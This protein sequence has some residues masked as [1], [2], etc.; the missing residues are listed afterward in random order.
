MTLAVSASCSLVSWWPLS[1]ESSASFPAPESATV[2]RDK[3]A[4]VHCSAPFRTLKPESCS[5][6]P[7]PPPCTQWKVPSCSILH[8]SQ[9]GLQVA[10]LVVAQYCPKCKSD[11][12]AA[13]GQV[14]R[15][16][17]VWWHPR[18]KASLSRGRRRPR[19][20]RSSWP[21]AKQAPLNNERLAIVPS[22]TLGFP[23]R[24]SQWNRGPGC[25]WSFV[26]GTTI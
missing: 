4:T 17:V 7:S 12:W 14:E 8:T 26:P 18:E 21:W 23:F 16:E 6:Q 13:A 10:H 15:S 11:R 25:P 3:V 2:P 5:F 9:S 19:Q 24:E 1:G 22:W 20:A